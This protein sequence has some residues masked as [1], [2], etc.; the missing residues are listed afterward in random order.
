MGPLKSF[1]QT[2]KGAVDTVW[3]ARAPG[4]EPGGWWGFKPLK[5]RW[6]RVRA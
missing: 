1:F 6:T 4:G 3:R 5:V 2:L